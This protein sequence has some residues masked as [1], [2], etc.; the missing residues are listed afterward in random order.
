[1]IEVLIEF[2]VWVVVVGLIFL[3]LKLC[4][5]EVMLFNDGLMLL[6]FLILIKFVD[7]KRL[8]LCL[9]VVGLFGIVIVVLFGKF[10]IDL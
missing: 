4:G 8:S 9:R 3:N 5:L 10:L 2:K 6:F 7:C 1:M